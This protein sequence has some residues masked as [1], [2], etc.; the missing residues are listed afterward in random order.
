MKNI[1]V[2]TN[3]E[4]GWD[5]VK[6]VFKASSKERVK[7]YLLEAYTE[8]YI[9]NT[10]V[11]HEKYEIIELED[12]ENLTGKQ[13]L[14]ILKEK[15]ISWDDLGYGYVD[16]KELQ[17]GEVKT[18]ENYGGEGMGEKYYKVYHF[19]KHDVYIRIDGYYQSYNGAEFENPPYEV[20]PIEKTVIFYEP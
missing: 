20:K 16:W 6:K 5:S 13:I 12:M 9:E 18:V 7:E 10:L 1:Y 17:L 15:K 14:E 19:I 3:P 8:D 2:V 11:I 4:D